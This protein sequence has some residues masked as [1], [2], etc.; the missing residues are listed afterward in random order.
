MGTGRRKFAG[1]ALLA[2]LGIA[3]GWAFWKGPLSPS[4]GMAS[5]ERGPGAEAPPEVSDA[6]LSARAKDET[7]RL[8]G[9]PG[10]RVEARGSGAV[11][12][13]VKALV[14]GVGEKPLPGAELTLVASEEG[15]GGASGGKA[16]T[17][18]EGA[19]GDDGTF[20][21]AP[22]PAR[23]GY[24]LRARRAPW[25]DVVVPAI[26]VT[27]GAATDVGTIVFGATTTLEGRVTDSA[28]RPLAAAAI[29]VERD[30]KGAPF[31][32]GR[33][34][35]D[36][37]VSPGALAE[38][39]TEGDGRFSL[40]GLPPGRYVLR[41]VRA[42]YA[43]AAV[44][45][46]VVTA[47]G[48]SPDVRVVLDP[49]AGFEGRVTDEDGRPIAKA[50]VL[51]VAFQ[52]D[53]RT[54]PDRQERLTDADG[55]YRF[56]TLTGGTNWFVEAHADGFAP[57]GTFKPT[58]P[59]RLVTLD[60][61]LTRGGR[62]EGKVYDARSG[63]PVP[64]ADV[65]LVTGMMGGG[66]APVGTTT[67][68]DGR[69]VL[70]NVIPGIVLRAEARAPG[71]SPG[72]FDYNPKTP[73]TVKSGETLVLDVPLGM[74]GRVV[75]MVSGIDG[76]P[77]AW[78][79]V[80]ARRDRRTVEITTLSDARGEYRI[81]GLSPGGWTVVVTAPG[82]ASPTADED[83]RVVVEDGKDV[84]KDF[85]LGE[86]AVI[87]GTVSSPDRIGIKGARV[88][89]VPTESR[90]VPRVRDLAAVTDATGA[91]RVAGVPASIDLVVEVEHDLWVA[92]RSA[93]VRVS[94]GETKRVD[95]A[96]KPGARI[97]GRAVDAA[98]RPVRGA[99]V[100][101]G[102]I[103]PEDRGRAGDSFRADA[104]LSDRVFA[105]DDGGNFSCDRARP[106]PVLLKVE[107]DGY[108]PWY[109]RDL[110]V[111][112]EGDLVGVTATL[113]G[114]GVVRGRVLSAEGSRPIRGAWIVAQTREAP[115]EARDEGRVRTLVT[116]ESGAD[117]AYAL[118]GV[119]PGFVDVVVWFAAGHV[120]A[121]N[122]PTSRRDAVTAGATGVDFRLVPVPPAD[123]GAK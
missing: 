39:R 96:L 85:V 52:P 4:W 88:V 7:L 14:P 119:P 112:E 22:V 18:V 9:I 81:P 24:V 28:G 50:R 44:S 93:P 105:A 83:V 123:G 120:T 26:A 6:E 43:S 59:Q 12:G 13:A 101:F 122:D 51:A 89:V 115:G 1:I 117:G 74:G 106:G 64:W 65:V 42:G 62:V 49:G 21:L 48:D 80:V 109:R 76:R 10:V 67:Q 98:G 34:L 33:I 17:K 60:F 8:R 84:R 29:L 79:S 30:S 78:A 102:A 69:Y 77:I 118:V 75:G 57:F 38:T 82:W 40:K 15:G 91:F 114:T 108:A 54:T 68:E 121:W 20:A 104:L 70:E 31:D 73:S 116:A 58:E 47:D 23:G 19:S 111:P 25:K 100:R 107:A 90:R 72:G 27:D 110:V 94:L 103:S 66:T 46:V 99:R 86:G 45:G 37:L 97:V 113:E 71:Y 63:Q 56:D 35:K 16:E 95:V 3:A 5:E 41:A 53:T 55:R 36:L 87:T 11:K 32:V 92:A 2:A 61:T